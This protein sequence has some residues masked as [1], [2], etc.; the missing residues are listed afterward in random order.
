MGPAKGLHT[1]R[2]VASCERHR[3]GSPVLSRPLHSISQFGQAYEALWNHVVRPLCPLDPS[4]PS[5]GRSLKESKN[6]HALVDGGRGSPMSRWMRPRL[7]SLLWRG[8]PNG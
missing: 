3:D 4:R 5:H 8:V 7:R 6:L 1:G 2:F